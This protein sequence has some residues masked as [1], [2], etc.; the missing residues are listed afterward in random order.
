MGIAAGPI[1]QMARAHLPNVPEN[2]GLMVFNVLKE[3]PAVV[4]GLERYDIILRADGQPVSNSQELQ[5]AVNRR[6]FGTQLRLDL[7]H[8][9][10]PKTAYCI[11]LEKP[12]GEPEPAAHRNPFGAL[13]PENVSIQFSFTDGEGK[14]Q[15]LSARTLAEFGQKTQQDEEFRNRMQQMFQGLPQNRQGI[16]IMLRP[17]EG[18]PAP[19]AP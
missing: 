9:G 16:T 12:E 4:A 15:S 6:N 1:P 14:R 2:Q 18:P 8:K 11:V 3:S 5:Q 13:K 10:Q 17:T 7:I 19:P